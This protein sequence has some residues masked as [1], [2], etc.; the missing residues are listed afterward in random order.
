MKPESCVTLSDGSDAQVAYDADFDVIVVG[1]GFGGVYALHRFSQQGFSVLGLESAAGVGGVWFHNRYPG[2]RVDLDSVDYSYFFSPELYREWRWSE[3][4]AAQPELLRY[5]NFAADRLDVRRHILFS[6]PMTGAQWRPQEGRYHVTAGAGRRFT[7]RFL[8]MATGNLSAARTPDFPGLETFKGEWVQTSHWPDMPADFQ[9][10]RIGVIGTGSSGVQAIPHLA[11]QASQ[12]HVF[13]RTP[14]FSV[15]AQNGPI[16][17][18]SYEAVAADVPA[19]RAR[20]FA[21]QGGITG[22]ERGAP[23]AS[24]TPAEQRERL[25]RQWARGGQGMKEVFADQ[26]VDQA[27]NDIVADFVR[28]KI[29]ETVKD[30][31]VAELLAPRDHPIGTRRLCLD[32]GYYETFNRPNVTLVDISRDPI[33]RIT[34][35]GIKTR[36]ASYDLDLIV[37]ALGFHA[38]SGAIDRANIRN[39]HGKSPTDHWDRG[40]RTMLGLMTAGFPNLFIVTGPGS[41]SVLVNMVLMNE[42]HIDWIADCIAYMREKG[43]ATIEPT[44]DAQ[45]AW[46]GH[47][48]EAA[49]PLLRVRVKNY[50]VHVNADGSHV[51]MPYVGGLAAYVERANQAVASGYE[52]FALK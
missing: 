26:S 25:E 18:A 38:F 43:F 49:R 1:A 11:E 6:T 23:A 14:N 37:F 41:P 16:D 30:P 13:Q 20:L 27:S 52:G 28:E 45:D 21:T 44:E 29:R 34:E 22:R 8:V 47:V 32:I 33:E 42:Y 7:C 50:M 36:A 5:I 31:A 15:P 2:A 19:A 17:P 39:E 4:Y 40:P 35:T 24:Y 48:A 12:L 51:F 46:T 10:R 3:R 9:G